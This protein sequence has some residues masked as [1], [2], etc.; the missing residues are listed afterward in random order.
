MVLEIWS[1]GF[2]EGSC[3]GRGPRAAAWFKDYLVERGNKS[4][5]SMILEGGIKGWVKA[6]EEYIELMDE[7]DASVWTK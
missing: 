4:I 6:G 3:G 1:N 7:Y 2:L 5:K